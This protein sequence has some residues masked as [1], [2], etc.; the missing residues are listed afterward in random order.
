MIAAATAPDQR[1]GRR[2][3]RDETLY[4]S[5]YQALHAFTLSG[6]R[7]TREALCGGTR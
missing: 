3:V 7:R 4:L 6:V 1:L 2:L 5:L